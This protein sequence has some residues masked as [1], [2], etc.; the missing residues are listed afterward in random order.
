MFFAGERID[1]HFDALFSRGL[2]A[3]ATDKNSMRR[4]GSGRVKVG[5]TRMTFRDLRVLSLWKKLYSIFCIC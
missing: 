2:A 4:V 1:L 5:L 3:A